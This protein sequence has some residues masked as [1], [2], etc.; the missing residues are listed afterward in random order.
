MILWQNGWIWTPLMPENIYAKSTNRSF[1]CLQV[2]YLSSTDW[3]EEKISSYLKLDKNRSSTISTLNAS[4]PQVIA[5][6]LIDRIWDWFWW[7]LL[8]PART[9]GSLG[10]AAWKEENV[11]DICIYVSI[12]RVNIIFHFWDWKHPNQ[13]LIYFYSVLYQYLITWLVAKMWDCTE[14]I[15]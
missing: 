4:L 3:L 10:V 15:G 9:V 2:T 7:N 5:A 14:L 1:L 6:N 13:T 12:S 11:R 8:N